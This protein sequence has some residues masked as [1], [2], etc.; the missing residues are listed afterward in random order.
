MRARITATHKWA[1]TFA[2]AAITIMG[3]PPANHSNIHVCLFNAW[4]FIQL[5]L[6]KTLRIIQVVL[7]YYALTLYRILGMPAICDVFFRPRGATVNVI[8]RIRLYG[9][10]NCILRAYPSHRASVLRKYYRYDTSSFYRP[11]LYIH[12]AHSN[13][14]TGLGMRLARGFIP[15]PL[16]PHQVWE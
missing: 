3:T 2:S 7:S 5:R 4:N 16:P 6:I 12:V 1:T 13:K 15:R 9:M 10:L 14:T 11:Q 8:L